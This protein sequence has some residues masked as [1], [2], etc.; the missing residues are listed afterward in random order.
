MKAAVLSG[1]SP[2]LL[3]LL[4]GSGGVRGQECATALKGAANLEAFT[5]EINSLW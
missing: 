2:L 5:N 4:L 3:L 1:L